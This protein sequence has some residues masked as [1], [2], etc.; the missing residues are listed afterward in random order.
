L[1]F[2]RER[3]GS[4]NPYQSP[5]LEISRQAR[6]DIYAPVTLIIIKM[7]VDLDCDLCHN[8]ITYKFYYKHMKSLSFL[9][10]LLLISLWLFI[11]KSI[12]AAQC[13]ATKPDHA[14]DLFQIDINKGSATLYFTPVNN[15]VTNYTIVYG[16][17]RGDER[18]GI[19][20]PY[21]VYHGVINYTV[22]HLSPN[23]RYYFRV[24][25]DNGCRQGFWSDTL[26]A[27]T[28]WHFKMYTRVK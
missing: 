24:R 18:W 19:S 20:F 7:W 9:I 1:L 14:P 25:A 5:L 11:P 13:L 21:G 16:L 26:S 10:I 28:N 8:E 4:R 3:S 6:N 17:S 2:S 12:S 22:N 15:A 23:T 27:R